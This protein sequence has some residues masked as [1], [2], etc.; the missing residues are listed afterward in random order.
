MYGFARSVSEPKVLLGI[1]FWM[2][3]DDLLLRALCALTQLT[4][5]WQALIGILASSR[6]ESKTETR[7]NRW[8]RSSGDIFSEKRKALLNSSYK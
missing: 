5:R 8:F 4:D 1:L 6:E 7:S 3:R 2:D